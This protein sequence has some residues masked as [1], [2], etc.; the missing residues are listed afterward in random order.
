MTKRLIT[1]LVLL[2]SSL[3]LCILSVKFLVNEID[4]SI[5]IILSD[6]QISEKSRLLNE[7][8]QKNGRVFSVFLKHT[9]ADFLERNFIELENACAMGNTE[10]AEEI[11]SQLYAYLA[12][13]AEA[14]KLRVENIF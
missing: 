3:M 2:S 13:T 9:D 6:N 5:E 1:A 14:E 10:K 7:H 8:W 4:N 12:V 11:I